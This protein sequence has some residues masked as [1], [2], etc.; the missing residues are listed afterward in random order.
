MKRSPENINAPASSR[1]DYE[2][3]LL[4][5]FAVCVSVFSFLYYFRQGDVLLYGDAVAHI[6]IARRVFDSRTPGLLQLGTVW[7]PLPHLL[8]IPFLIFD[9]MWRSGA[10]GSI[11]SMCAYVFGVVGMF[12]LVRGGLGAVPTG[13]ASPG[14][15]TRHFRAGLS[16][17]AATRLESDASR[18]S[19]DPRA[20]PEP[21]GSTGPRASSVSAH[22][23]Q[24]S[25]GFVYD[26]AA[27]VAAWT[28]AVIYGANPNLIYM[29]T[30]AMGEALYLAFFIWAVI[31]LGE[32]ARGDEKALA[33]CGSC[34][35]AACLTRYDGWF[36][37][38]IVGAVVVGI[39]LRRGYN[40]SGAFAPPD[41][42][43]RLSPHDPSPHDPSPHDP[44]PH[45]LG[46]S[47]HKSALAKFL[48]LT[49]AGPALWL[50][51]NAAVYGNP[52][53]FANGPYSAKAVEK[54]TGTIN[55]AN[56]NLYA[57]AMYFVKSAELNVAEAEWLGR[58][59]L[60][61][62]VA[63]AAAILIWTRAAWP[64]LLLWT[65]LPFYALSLAYGSVP[66]FVPVWWPFSHYNVRYG[67]ELLPAMAGSMAVLVGA[68]LRSSK[69]PRAVRLVL[70]LAVA[71]L[72]T[73]GYV[74]AWRSEPISYREAAINMR[75]RI[76]LERQLANW[77]R[78]LP[79]NATLLMYLGE[80]PGA[81]QVAGVPLR[82]V[83]N[84]GNHRV[85]RQPVDPEGLWERALADP[86]K[87]ADYVVAF[88][89]DTVWQAVQARHLPEL[90]EINVTG[91]RRAILYRAR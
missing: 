62:A 72:V 81:A 21:R 22:P 7:L 83:I 25:S 44:S 41:S 34:L 75:G 70:I 23:L 57:G 78:D 65:P 84:E 77:L 2:V 87:F 20:S 31:Y 52:L 56:G 9:G 66:I 29:Q 86:S 39:Y 50:A 35:A 38:V 55:P 30:T 68:A 13:L 5:F 85:W 74:S 43:G 27:R 69:S 6:N 33:K 28:A 80:H 48:L 12:R 8:M 58:F 47:L 59:W 79:P 49:V 60:L 73:A 17:I 37:A 51:Y 4:A 88:E 54:N 53:E 42:R 89:G 10:A 91:Q 46:L 40:H 1:W 90:V 18:V 3:R 45:G 32:F 26:P 82:R 76:A 24:S 61:L 11:P 14:G 71:A 15:S 19:A 63:G 64:I 36:L 16:N 67:L